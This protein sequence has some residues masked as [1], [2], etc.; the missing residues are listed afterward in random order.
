[1]ALVYL[2]TDVKHT[3]RVAIK[4]LKPE[5]AASLGSERFLRN[6][7]RKGPRP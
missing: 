1:M 2:G 6:V 7:L 3:R 5:L 4:V